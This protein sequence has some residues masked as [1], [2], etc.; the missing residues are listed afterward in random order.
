VATWSQPLSENERQQSV[1]DLVCCILDNPW[2][3]LR[4]LLIIEVLAAFI[5]DIV[6]INTATPQ[7]ERQYSVN[8]A[9]TKR[10]QSINTASIEC[11]QSVNDFGCCIFY[12]LRALLRHIP[13]INVSA[14]V[15][16]KRDSDMVISPV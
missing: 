1:N 8:R 13:R 10:Q 9:S 4:R 2:A 16:S 7:T 11:Q 15:M 14:A 3:M 5:G 12:N 6:C